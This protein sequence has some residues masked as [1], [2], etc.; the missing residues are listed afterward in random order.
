M[1]KRLKK[2]YR[3][4]SKQQK[5][6]FSSNHRA[7]SSPTSKDE[8]PVLTQRL[9]EATHAEMVKD[10]VNSEQIFQMMSGFPDQTIARVLL[11]LAREKG[12]KSLPLL[13][14]AVHHPNP[15][16]VIAAVQ[17]L[18][19]IRCPEAVLI[20]TRMVEQNQWDLEKS[21][22]TKEL[23]KELNRSL[24][25]LKSAG[26]TPVAPVAK[27]NESNIEHSAP[28]KPAFNISAERQYQQSYVS[29]LDGSGNIMGILVMRSPGGKLETAVILMNDLIGLKD[30]RIYSFNQRELS[31]FLAE[32]DLKTTGIR[33][34]PTKREYLNYLIMVHE[35]KNKASNSPLPLDF[36]AWRRYFKVSDA[37][38][39][40]LQHPVYEI[41]SLDEIKD[42]RSYLLPLSENL[43]Q[44]PEMRN[45]L[46]EPS[47][48]S[49]YAQKLLERRRSR[50]VVAGTFL[51]EFQAKLVQGIIE[52]LFGE[53]LR[54]SYQRR[55]EHMAMIFLST[56][57]LSNARLALAAALELQNGRQPTQQPLLRAL[58]NSSLE[59]MVKVLENGQPPE[60]MK[61]DPNYET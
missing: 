8:F 59:A 7:I 45:W 30:C 47:I 9:L 17:A 37:E 43:V 4:D 41:I 12:E 1:S 2:N 57:Q 35:Q 33:V 10:Q 54:L 36:V 19:L 22:I 20:L 29:S 24:H 5:D 51:Q 34:V 27:S 40:R 15:Q 6:S 44:T 28:A 23:K 46:L 42:S 39:A 11:A 52:N 25:H 13:E 14:K 26:I 53:E 55:L 60:E 48:V 18:G 16:V 32:W 31:G 58:A 49:D 21:S 38:Q 3:K 50:I 56:E 61:N